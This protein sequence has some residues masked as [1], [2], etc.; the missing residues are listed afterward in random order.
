MKTLCLTYLFT[1]NV[2]NFSSLIVIINEKNLS[3]QSNKTT[4][5][6]VLTS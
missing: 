4:P 6:F 1:D 5:V 3:T 2:N